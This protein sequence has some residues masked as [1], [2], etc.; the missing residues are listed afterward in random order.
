M[1]STHVSTPSEDTEEDW[2]LFFY[3]GD[4]YYGD[5]LSSM[6]IFATYD[7][8]LKQ[9]EIKIEVE[10]EKNFEI[11]AIWS[12]GYYESYLGFE[13]DKVIYLPENLQVKI[14]IDDKEL[15]G[16]CHSVLNYDDIGNYIGN[17]DLI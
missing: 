5:I 1:D 8:N 16:K 6:L 10:V 15:I 9:A 2:C 12:S 13:E 17:I 11:P 3:N 7:S 4:G 14:T